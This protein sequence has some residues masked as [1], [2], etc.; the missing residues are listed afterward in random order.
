MHKMTS[1]VAAVLLT[2]AVTVRLS[3]QTFFSTEPDVAPSL[4][5][6]DDAIRKQLEIKS[7]QLNKVLSPE[8]KQSF[9]WWKIEQEADPIAVH[10]AAILTFAKEH[11]MT[12][13]SFG[14]LAYLVEWGEGEPGTLFS[15][16]CDEILAN[17]R[18]NPA[19]SWLCS[20]CT[21]PLKYKVMRSFLTRVQTVS[22]NPDVRAAAK[23]QLARLL[24]NVIQMHHHHQETRDQ[25]AEIGAIEAHPDLDQAIQL[26]A[27]S[28]PDKL[29]A[30]RDDLL[31]QVSHE[32]GKPWTVDRTFGRLNYNFHDDPEGR[33]IGQLAESLSYEIANLRLGCMAPDFTGK[34]ADG[35]EFQLRE[36][37]GKPTLLMFSFKGCAACES[38]YPALRTV[39]S[40]FSGAGFS[41]IGVM[42]DRQADTVLA[43]QKSGSITWPCVWDG[44]DGPIVESYRIKGFPTVILLDRNGRI[45]AT[46]LRDEKQLI[47]HIDA[48]LRADC[49][50]QTK[51]STGAAVKCR[52]KNQRR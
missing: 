28:N 14:C 37:R 12:P 46:G 51:R 27:T 36:R 25:L 42:A 38:M 43:A 9:E 39:Q 19:L 13:E 4:R 1:I 5:P 18:N 30:E 48:L 26:V 52:N 6:L 33:S 31:Q 23:L 16:T 22:D 20:R 24:D 17:H 50:Q 47:S 29:A 45:A 7:E 15:S 8:G 40:R 2:Q 41:V 3:G 34:S 21:N 35:V 11:P 32:S 49:G 44:T 10:G